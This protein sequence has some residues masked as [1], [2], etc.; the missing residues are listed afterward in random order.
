MELTLTDI[1]Q[2]VC[3]YKNQLSLVVSSLEREYRDWETVRGRLE[4]QVERERLKVRA[5]DVQIHELKLSKEQEMSALSSQLMALR[6]QLES[7]NR[8]LKEHMLD[9]SVCTKQPVHS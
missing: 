4:T 6:H 5:R 9:S 1:E 2:E 3:R 8:E 7:D